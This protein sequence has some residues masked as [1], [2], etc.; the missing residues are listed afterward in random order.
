[1]TVSGSAVSRRNIFSD[2]VS[3]VTMNPS[4][5]LLHIHGIRRQIPVGY[6]MTIV[7]KLEPLL[8]YRC[9]H[10]DKWPKGRIECSPHTLL[11]R[12]S[13]CAVESSWHVFIIAVIAEPHGK[14]NVHGRAANFNFPGIRRRCDLVDPQGRGT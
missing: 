5:A 7:M 11:S 14:P 8:A 1:M 10:Q 2:R 12:Y 3:F 4:L 6:R 13:R 9:C